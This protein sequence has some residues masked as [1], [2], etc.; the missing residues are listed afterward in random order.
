MRHAARFTGCRG[1]SRGQHAHRM[2]ARRYG[3]RSLRARCRYGAPAGHDAERRSHARSRPRP[4]G[5]DSEAGYRRAGPHVALMMDLSQTIFGVHFQNPVL[6]AS[7]TSGYGAEIDGFYD[8]DDL[9]GIVIKAVT[10][11]VRRGNPAP[12]VAEF[13]AG[14]INSVG[15]ANPGPAVV[16]NEKLPWLAQRLTRA[17]VLVNVAGRSAEEYGEIIRFL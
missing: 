9:G 1:H 5:Y 15:L 6:L 4:A 10:A 8:I 12:R 17:R 11:D 13:A 14:M 2:P 16:K 3:A 7:G